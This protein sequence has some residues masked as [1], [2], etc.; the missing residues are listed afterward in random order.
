MDGHTTIVT[1]CLGGYSMSNQ[2]SNNQNKSQNAQQ[3]KAKS[4]NQNKAQNTQ[5]NKSQNCCNKEKEES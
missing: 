3:N 4:A 2:C 1:K 5:Q